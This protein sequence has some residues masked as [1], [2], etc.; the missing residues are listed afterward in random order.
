MKDRLIEERL[1]M[2]VCVCARACVYMCVHVCAFVC[3]FM[4]VFMCLCVCVV[5]DMFQP[6][7]QIADPSE[8]VDTETARPPHQTLLVEAGRSEGG[9]RWEG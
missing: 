9:A 8:K 1:H 2:H 5:C 4:R 6:C 3:V 7:N